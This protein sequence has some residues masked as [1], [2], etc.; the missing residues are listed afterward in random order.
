MKHG[1]YLILWLYPQ[2]EEGRMAGDDER[3]TYSQPYV[4]PAALPCCWGGGGEE[5]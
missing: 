2:E 1:A 4:S 3:I 5:G